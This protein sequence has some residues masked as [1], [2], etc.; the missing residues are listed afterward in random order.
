MQKASP[1][2]SWYYEALSAC[3]GS[4]LTSHHS[5]ATSAF[6]MKG[7]QARNGDRTFVLWSGHRHDR[8][9]ML[10]A[11]LLD[12][13]GGTK[14]GDAAAN[15]AAAHFL[16]AFVE[17]QRA[18]EGAAEIEEVLQAALSRADAEIC[19]IFDGA[20]GTTLTAV[21]MT[22]DCCVAVHIG[23]SRLYRIP[24]GI[25]QI[26]RDDAGLFGARMP[27]LLGDGLLQF[28]DT[29]ASMPHQSYDLRSNFPKRLLLTS[30]GLHD[31]GSRVLRRVV[32]GP[33]SEERLKQDEAYWKLLDNASAVY[34]RTKYARTQ[35]DWLIPY[36]LR[37]VCG[38]KRASFTMRR[39]A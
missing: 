3:D 39:D 26:T 10:T 18:I 2:L 28:V 11:G 36:E 16:A 30:D 9:P 5:P 1:D 17:E 24:A 31:L 25:T 12:G 21:A 6:S 33:W 8:P 27:A 32:R 38:H 15:V 7:P 19:G 14:A 20:S 23:D 37:L 35:L 4:R 34:I 22:Q 29:G 13:I